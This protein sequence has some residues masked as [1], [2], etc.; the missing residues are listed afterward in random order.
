MGFLLCIYLDD[1]LVCSRT[2]EEH[3]DHLQQVFNRLEEAKLTLKPK[4]CSFLQ[5][6]VIYLG[7]MISSKGIGV[8][9][10]IIRHEK[11]FCIPL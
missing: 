10:Y 11:F 1:I 3:L 2:L 6:E 9:Y 4:K 5:D 8:M 7:H